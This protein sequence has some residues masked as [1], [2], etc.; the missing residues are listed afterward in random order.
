[1]TKSPG[2]NQHG[3]QIIRVSIFFRTYLRRIQK[4]RA[5]KLIHTK[6][7]LR[8]SRE[9]HCA[10]T[11][12]RPATEIQCLAVAVVKD[13]E[14]VCYELLKWTYL[15]KKRGQPIKRELEWATVAREIAAMNKT[16]SRAYSS[17]RACFSPTHLIRFTRFYQYFMYPPSASITAFTSYRH[18]SHQITS[19]R[20]SF[21]SILTKSP[22][23][24]V[25]SS[26]SSTK[27]RKGHRHLT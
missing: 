24:K 6:H 11:R 20:T 13:N 25:V 19:Y 2:T 16:S 27:R 22:L 23:S 14:A 17:S 1:V 18:I 7:R 4:A 8:Y 15:Q 26:V 12:P 3:A 21:Q 9:S 5:L 10:K